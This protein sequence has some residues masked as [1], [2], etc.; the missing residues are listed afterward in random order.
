MSTDRKEAAS[1]ITCVEVMETCKE[2]DV[3]S[4]KDISVCRRIETQHNTR[5][6]C[7]AN[8]EKREPQDT[9][10]DMTSHD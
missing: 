6:M 3:T 9:L 5:T 4:P 7:E 8:D 2:G 10:S 1:V